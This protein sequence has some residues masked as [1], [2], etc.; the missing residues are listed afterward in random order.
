MPSK[1]PIDFSVYREKR[2]TTFSSDGSVSYESYQRVETA[3][4]VSD[5]VRQR[6][7]A[8]P[9]LDSLGI[10]DAPYSIRCLG[11]N[12]GPI[13]PNRTYWYAHYSNKNRSLG[14]LGAQQ[15]MIIDRESAEVVYDGSDGEE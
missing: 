13:P 11:Y 6:L 10:L 7:L 2:S 1:P 15:V 9:N 14:Y 8:I 4:V 5:A 12:R 3:L